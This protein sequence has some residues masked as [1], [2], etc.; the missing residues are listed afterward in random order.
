MRIGN[1][2]RLVALTL[3]LI[4]ASLV[5]ARTHCGLGTHDASSEL[6]P[7]GSTDPVSRGSGR[8]HRQE[9]TRPQAPIG[10]WTEA[11]VAGARLRPVRPVNLFD[12]LRA[13][14]AEPV[15]TET[16][17]SGRV[18]VVAR[19]SNVVAFRMLPQTA[20]SPWTATI[21]WASFQDGAC[22]DRGTSILDDRRTSRFSAG[23]I[24]VGA[25][26]DGNGAMYL[27]A[28][29]DLGTWFDM[30]T[31]PRWSDDHWT[32]A[33]DGLTFRRFDR[34]ENWMCDTSPD[35]ARIT[36]APLATLRADAPDR[37]SQE[38]GI[39]KQGG[40]AGRVLPGDVLILISAEGICTVRFSAVGTAAYEFRYEWRKWTNVG[41]GGLVAGEPGSGVVETEGRFSVAHCGSIGVPLSTGGDAGPYV[42]FPW[43]GSTFLCVAR[44]DSLE[45]VNPFDAKHEY[46]RFEGDVVW[47]FR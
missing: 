10:I 41:G 8:L 40:R 19:D 16:V 39:R 36:S 9:D 26:L 4:G 42:A 38:R 21:E 15:F 44:D 13:D 1:R 5:I 33:L 14:G 34:D 12:D 29:R 22:T 7:A 20:E 27:Y 6:S 45:L 25:S 43:S 2:T 37:A 47:R 17:R 46:R 31:A 32:I 30:W 35:Q 23:N 3:L 24:E 28:A 18:V 11:T